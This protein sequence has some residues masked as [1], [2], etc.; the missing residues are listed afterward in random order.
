MG[1][2]I[3]SEAVIAEL[4]DAGVSAVRF[5]LAWGS[6][7]GHL[8]AADMVHKVAISKGKLCAMMLDVS[9]T[10]CQVM[11]PYTVNEDGTP[12]FE[13]TVT[14]QQGQEVTLSEAPD[15]EL[16]VPPVRFSG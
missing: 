10:V 3:N 13:H 16:S 6:L 4:L 2:A 12:E 5:D 11:Q 9:G 14:L 1:P 15:A 8:A 7:E